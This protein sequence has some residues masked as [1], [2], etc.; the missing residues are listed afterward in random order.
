MK[1]Q[2]EWRNDLWLCDP[3]KNEVCGKRTCGWLRRGRC[4][5]TNKEE[6]AR[7]DEEGNR[8][9][10]N[11]VRGSRTI[12]QVALLQTIDDLEKIREVGIVNAR[13]DLR[14]IDETIGWLELLYH[15]IGI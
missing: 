15:L 14:V 8:L 2:N 1:M 3:D 11:S 13:N 10:V 4:L 7:E 9:T 5:G 6:C 12:E